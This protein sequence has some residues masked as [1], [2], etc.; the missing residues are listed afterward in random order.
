[1]IVGHPGYGVR[2]PTS[3]TPARRA[4]SIRRTTTIDIARP[5]GFTG[6][7]YLSG[8]GRDVLTGAHG[9]WHAVDQGAFTT[10]VDYPQ[11]RTLRSLRC[12]PDDDALTALV[13]SSATRGFRHALDGC[14]PTP[15]QRRSVLYQLLD[16]VPV[17]V[18]IAGQAHAAEEHVAGVPPLPLVVPPNVCSGWQENATMMTSLRNGIRP[19]VFGPAAPSLAR[20]DDPDAWHASPDPHPTMMRRHRRMDIFRGGAS[21]HVETFLRD[22]HWP[23]SGP[24]RGMETVLHEY[25]VRA[26]IRTGDHTLERIDTLRHVLP[27]QECSSAAASPQR[28]VGAPLDSLAATIRADFLGAGYCTHLNDVLRTLTRVPLLAVLLPGT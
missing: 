16:D 15:G 28:L 5:H 8:R 26:V 23:G 18:L 6:G 4:D 3:G 24:H 13:D 22:S 17:A 19:V 20:D 27:W 14:L 10:D 7:L 21:W 9:A 2:E 1:M 25:T 12:A 11:G